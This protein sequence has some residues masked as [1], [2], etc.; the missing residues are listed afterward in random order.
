M[1]R[2]MNSNLV[3]PFRAG[4]HLHKSLGGSRFLGLLVDK[5]N[6]AIQSDRNA[7]QSYSGRTGSVCV[8]FR[9]VLATLPMIK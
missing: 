6:S 7:T 4:D 9:I 3:S 8:K 1:T 2:S 5:H